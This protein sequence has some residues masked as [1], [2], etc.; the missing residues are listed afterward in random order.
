MKTLQLTPSIVSDPYYEGFIDLSIKYA[1]I[2]N[3]DGKLFVRCFLKY[4]SIREACE[5][6]VKSY[7][8]AGIELEGD[9]SRYAGKQNLPEKWRGVLDMVLRVIYTIS[10][11]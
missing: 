10:K 9:F 11:A 6:I 8:R 5:E 1:E 4:K 7:K 2:Y 3:R